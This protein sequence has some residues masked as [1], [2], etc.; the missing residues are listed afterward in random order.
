MIIEGDYTFDGPREAVWDLLLDPE[1][2]SRALPGSG[3]LE[4]TDEHRYE[5]RVN[6]G[7][8]PVTAAEFTV[9]LTLSE[10]EHPA[11]YVMVIDGKG[12]I[13]F[14]K[15]R[16][17]VSLTEVEGGTAL[18][19]RADLQV[20]GKIAGVGQRLLDSV[21]KAMT[22]QGLAALNK[23]LQ[24][25]LTAANEGAEDDPAPPAPTGAVTQAASTRAAALGRTGPNLVV[26]ALGAV[27][28]AVVLYL[29]YG[30]LR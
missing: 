26:R 30:L 4:Q 17:E 20:G 1:I 9:S 3:G 18:T 2:L 28:I 19:Y 22:K 11:R 25:R 29:L 21:S 13:G 14:T 7:V 8:G 6:V 10:L 16:A 23:E 27:A 12:P 5:G 24:G 15:G